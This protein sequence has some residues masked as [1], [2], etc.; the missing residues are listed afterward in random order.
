[1]MKTCSLTC[2]PW[3][4]WDIISKF[5]PCLSDYWKG[6]RI[7]SL[8]VHQWPLYF[9]CSF[10]YFPHF[11]PDITLPNNA[12]GWKCFILSLWKRINY[13]SPYCVCKKKIW[14]QLFNISYWIAI[15]TYYFLNRHCVP[16]ENTILNHKFTLHSIYSS[17]YLLYKTLN[18]LYNLLPVNFSPLKKFCLSW[19]LSS[20]SPYS[21]HTSNCL[22]WM[23]YYSPWYL[24]LPLS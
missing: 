23:L 4:A 1:M 10:S 21:Q 17:Q 12:Y 16:R 24:W 8:T 15:L 2:K 3:T 7:L 5:S 19:V 6:A 18:K 13:I 9:I 22:Q 11:V 20:K 14:V